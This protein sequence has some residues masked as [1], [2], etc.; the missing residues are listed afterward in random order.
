MRLG[1]DTEP[2]C[3]YS[4]N[5]TSV[6]HHLQT[7]SPAIDVVGT[8]VVGPYSRTVGVEGAGNVPPWSCATA[9]RGALAI[10]N[11]VVSRSC[12]VGAR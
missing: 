1:S 9:V 12:V 7:H 10:G 8:S 5:T 3:I 4:A 6:V 2:Y 11:G